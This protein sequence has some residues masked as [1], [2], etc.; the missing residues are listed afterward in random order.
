[1]LTTRERLLKLNV[2]AGDSRYLLDRLKVAVNGVP[3]YGSAGIDLRPHHAKTWTKDI[4]VELSAGR[5]RI[6]VSVLNEKGAESHREHVVIDCEAPAGKPDLYAVV[7]GVSEYRDARFRLT[8]ADKDARDLAA[9]FEGRRGRFREVK[10]LPLLNREATREKILAARHLLKKS[11]VDD[12]V[13]LFFAGHGLLDAKLDYYFA[14]ADVDFRKPARR[15]LPYEAIE[16]LLDGI[17]ARQKLLLMDTCH[18]GELDREG[19]RLAKAEKIPEGRIKTR[20]FRGLDFDGGPRLGPNSFELLQE[21]FADL[22]RGTGAVVIASAGGAEYALESE[23]WK[24]GVFTYALLR[25]LK[26]G[27]RRDGDG[28]LRVSALRDFVRRE[29]RRLTRGRQAPTSRRENLELDF[30]VD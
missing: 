30:A 8:Y 22:R 10:V 26:G 14:T 16:G 27:A 29:V 28:R 21:D 15:G 25:G 9:F 7:V 1:L 17:P 4:D 18:A 20:S 2:K 5:N 13:V 3:V 19:V 6:D 23:A 11:R 24:N 12:L